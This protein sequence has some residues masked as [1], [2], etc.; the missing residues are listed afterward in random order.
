MAL[1]SMSLRPKAV[2]LTPMYLNLLY[3]LIIYLHTLLAALVPRDPHRVPDG[4]H[5]SLVYQ[6]LR[7]RNQDVPLHEV[8]RVHVDEVAVD[9]ATGRRQ[10]H[11]CMG[12]DMHAY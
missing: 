8:T 11:T 10:T 1:K 9:T 5:R 7:G 2:M 6:G 3:I 4:D 12:V